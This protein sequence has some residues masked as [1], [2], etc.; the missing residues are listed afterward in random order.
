MSHPSREDGLPPGGGG[1]YGAEEEDDEE[2]AWEDEAERD[3][4][5]G[6]KYVRTPG[7]LWLRSDKM[8]RCWMCH[9]ENSHVSTCIS[10]ACQRRHA[11]R[12]RDERK[13][14]NKGKGKRR[15]RG[16]K[17]EVDR[18]R[19]RGNQDCDRPCLRG[20]PHTRARSQFPYR[21]G[22]PPPESAHIPLSEGTLSFLRQPRHWQGRCDMREQA[23]QNLAAEMGRPFEDTVHRTCPFGSDL[24]CSERTPSDPIRSIRSGRIGSGRMGSARS[25]RDWVGSDPI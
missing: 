7:R 5:A 25:A 21:R 2:D 20:N 9:E 12:W 16:A 10:Q 3:R 17:S 11:A 19:Q 6:Y 13:G 14:S 1:R 4:R 8:R 22:H 23:L 24:S 15:W 18:Q